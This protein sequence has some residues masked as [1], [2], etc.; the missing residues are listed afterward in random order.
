MA[1]RKFFVVEK[2]NSVFTVRIVCAL[3]FRN[4]KHFSRINYWGIK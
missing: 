4:G 2:K 3:D 1:L